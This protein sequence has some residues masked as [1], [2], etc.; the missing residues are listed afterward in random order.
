MLREGVLEAAGRRVDAAFGLH[1]FSNHLPSGLF[2]SRPGTILS[3]SHGLFVTAR[4]R[5]TPATRSSRR[6]R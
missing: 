1:G 6:P 3:A 4:R 2:S 5:T